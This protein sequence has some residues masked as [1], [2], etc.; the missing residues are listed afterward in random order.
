MRQR[1]LKYSIRS[2]A[3]RGDGVTVKRF[4]G[5]LSAREDSEGP[6]V[7]DRKDSDRALPRRGR[8]WFASSTAEAETGDGTSQ[9]SKASGRAR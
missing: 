1:E 2:I 4:T 8:Q 7:R 5:W 6:R 9:A 3:S